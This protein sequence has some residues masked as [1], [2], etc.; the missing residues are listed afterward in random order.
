MKAKMFLATLVAVICF[1]NVSFSQ[2]YHSEYNFGY[3]VGVGDWAT[4]RINIQTIQGLKINDNF[5]AGIGIGLDCYS[6]EEE[7]MLP[8]TI[9]AKVYLP[10]S[11]KFTPFASLDLGYGI[12]IS[13]EISGGIITPAIGIKS[14][15]LMTQ[16][17]YNSQKLTEDGF[18]LNMSAIQFKLGIM[19]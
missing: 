4:D 2:N 8:I 12:G 3:S 19:F 17:G 1:S 15:K 9:N 18:S 16:I 6:E 10:T 11:E 7:Y 5:T 13:D 14:G